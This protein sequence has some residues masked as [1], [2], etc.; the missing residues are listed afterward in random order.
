[1]INDNRPE[2]SSYNTSSKMLT[3]CGKAKAK[4]SATS[5]ETIKLLEDCQVKASE[6]K[7]MNGVA[8]VNEWSTLING[9]KV[10]F[11]HS[12]ASTDGKFHFR[13]HDGNVSTAKTRDNVIDA[14]LAEFLEHLHR[15]D[16][17]RPDSHETDFI[18]SHLPSAEDFELAYRMLAQLGEDI[19]IDSVLDQ[20]EIN[21]KDE[22]H[23]L[24]SN[25]RMVTE[26]NIEIWSK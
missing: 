16:N 12:I 15:Q 8:L 13:D 4:M 10:T 9:E 24:K 21:L 3:A 18:T 19:S 26:K 23:L 1:M 17:E 11:C 7:D 6:V 14:K 2:G 5:P 20:I 22:G 25:W